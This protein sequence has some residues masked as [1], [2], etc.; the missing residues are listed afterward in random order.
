MRYATPVLA[1]LLLAGCTPA[2]SPSADS[3]PSHAETGGDSPKAISHPSLA[4]AERDYNLNKKWSVRLPGNLRERL[5]DGSLV[6]WRKGMTIYA[7]V[8]GNDMGEAAAERLSWIKQHM[9]PKAFEVRETQDGGI[10][11]LSYRLTEDREEGTVHALYGYAIG[12]SGHV[13]MAVYLDR[14]S[15][16]ESA[17]KIFLSVTEHAE[18]E[19]RK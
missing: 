5:E 15:D 4:T 7:V 14:E 2:P 13:Q 17:R 10:L 3:G 9:S 8:W 16:L 6:F 11:R 12:R 1:I 18:T 19:Q